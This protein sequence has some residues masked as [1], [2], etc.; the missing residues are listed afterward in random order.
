MSKAPS[1]MYFESIVRPEQEGRCLL[2]VLC[3]RFTYH[4]REEWIDRLGRGLVSINGEVADTDTVAHKNDKV[5]YHVENYTEPDVPTDFSIVFEDEEFLVVAKPAGTPVH[6]TGRIFYNT[7]AAIVRRATDCETA[8]PMHRLDRD[9][10]GLMLFAKYAETAARFQK[11][12]DRILL[13]K[14]YLAVVEGVFPEGETRCDLPLREDP[15]DR[16]RLRM[17]H[18]EDGKECHT[19]FRK[20]GSLERDGHTYSLLE[21]E[22]ITGRKHQI[23]AHLAEL[24]FPIVGDRLYSH[25]G[26]YYEKMARGGG[27]DEND[28]R[29]LGA[30]YQMLYAYRAEI[31][32]PYWKEPR[33]FRSMDFPE[34]MKSLVDGF[35]LHV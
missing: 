11:N 35:G 34:E 27:L 4:S 20:L 24:G 25:D 19:V 31:A 13:R 5:L 1:D 30:R 2:D 22:L 7:F 28:Y 17:H 21:A 6:H 9:T 10:G 26:I 16:L 12:L 23:R 33:T 29:V 18:L 8:T 3:K 14:F 32:L 15:D